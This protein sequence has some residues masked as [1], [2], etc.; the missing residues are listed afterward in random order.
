MNLETM[1]YEERNL[2]LYLETCA[3][4]YGGS[5]EAQRMNGD[6]FLIADSWVN[7]GF[8]RF[9]RIRSKDIMSHKG[10]RRVTHWVELSDAAWALAHAERRARFKR[11][12]DKR[13][14]KTTDEHRGRR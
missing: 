5:V 1:S 11:L 9:G 3:V 8:I 6:D 14:W 2:L 7:S 12:N 13:W 4:D 10:N